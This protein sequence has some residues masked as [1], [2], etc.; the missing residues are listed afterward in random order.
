MWSSISSVGKSN[1]F[2]CGSRVVIIV[3]LTVHSGLILG[4]EIKFW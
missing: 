1:I 3:A 4:Y 2:N